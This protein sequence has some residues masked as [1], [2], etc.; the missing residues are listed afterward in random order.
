[1][2]VFLFTKANNIFIKNPL[3]FFK[4]ANSKGNQYPNW[5][6]SNQGEVFAIDTTNTA[7]SKSKKD[8][9][10]SIGVSEDGTIWAIS[11]EP[12]PD[13]GGSKLYWSN[14]DG[15]WT[16]IDTPDPGGIYQSTGADNEGCIYKTFDGLL[17]RMTTQCQSKIP[18][19]L[20]EKSE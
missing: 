5:T 15:N 4:M 17:I 20:F 11:Y 18:I 2:Q 12:D 9:A 13:G 8:F 16:E 10:A 7:T 3:I 14:G 6:I 1:M 19:S